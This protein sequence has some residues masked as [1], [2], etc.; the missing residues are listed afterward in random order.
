MLTH[1]RTHTHACPLPPPPAPFSLW[2]S[3]A[4]AGRTRDVGRPP[5]HLNNRYSNHLLCARHGA[6]R[7][8]PGRLG[9]PQR[10]RLLGKLRPS[11]KGPAG[12]YRAVREP[13][14][15]ESGGPGRTDRRARQETHT[16][17]RGRGSTKTGRCQVASSR[18][19]QGA[20]R[21]AGV[22]WGPGGRVGGVA[23]EVVFS[24]VRQGLECQA[25]GLG[26]LPGRGLARV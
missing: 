7:C 5:F 9:L 23:A 1:G 4:A 21:R 15:G 17:G 11:G 8:I 3:E 22:G 24:Q 13:S 16:A 2:A 18:D 26:F 25:Q 10:H 6:T 14:L 20:Q 19:L 12:Q